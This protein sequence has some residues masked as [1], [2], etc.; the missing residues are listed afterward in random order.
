[1]AVAAVSASSE[2]SME[3]DTM[4]IPF[5]KIL[6]IKQMADESYLDSPQPSGATT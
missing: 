3:S 1:V 2:F 4:D 6:G 5:N